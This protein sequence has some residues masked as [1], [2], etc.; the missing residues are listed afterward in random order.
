M[1]YCFQSL[2]TVTLNPHAVISVSF[3]VLVEEKLFKQVSD[4][5]SVVP[6]VFLMFVKTYTNLCIKLELYDVQ[7]FNR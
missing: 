5:T 4:F 3:E 7:D 2:V 6:L 1:K